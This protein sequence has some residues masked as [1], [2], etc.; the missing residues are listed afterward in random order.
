MRQQ[1]WIIPDTYKY[2]KKVDNKKVKAPVSELFDVTYTDGKVTVSMKNGID[3]P[4]GAYT[5]K[6]TKLWD[7]ANDAALKTPLT[8]SSLRVTVRD[9]APTV[10]VKMSGKMDL[11]NRRNSTLKGTITVK[12]MNSTVQNIALQNDYA[13][14]YYII[15]KDN[16]FT[17]YAKKDAQLKTTTTTVALLITMSDGTELTK[18]VSFKPIQSTPKV[19]TPKA[20]TIYKAA[21]AQTVDYDFNKDITKG[22]RISNITSTKLPEGF[23]LQQSNGHLFVT[24]EDKALKAGTYNISVNVYISGAQ[25]VTDNV[26]GKP[27][28]K[29]IAVTVKE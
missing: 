21:S 14:D 1:T 26:N 20:L 23:K 24:L 2:T 13:D 12:Y 3:V 25:A 22:V 8:T 15:P 6:M 4:S 10:S 11:I 9:T 28:P 16:T 7:K 17:L 5:F 27:I 19:A 18:A 29:T